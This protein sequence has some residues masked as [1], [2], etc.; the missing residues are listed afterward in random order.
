VIPRAALV[1]WGAK[2]P[3][4]TDEDIE[5]DLIMSRLMI[6][7]AND[8]LLGPELVMRGGTCLHKIHLPEPLRYSEDLDYNRRT[9]SG[10]GPYVNAIEAVAKN[11]GLRMKKF[12]RGGQM[13]TVVLDCDS[14]GGLRLIRIKVETNVR[15]TTPCYPII[16]RPHEVKSSWWSGRADVPTFELAELMGTKLR[17]LYQRSRGRDLFDLW[18]VLTETKVDDDRLVAAFHH[19]MGTEAFGFPQLREN[20]RDKL[21]DTAFSND[22]SDL[23][24]ATPTGYDL[25]KAADLFMERIGSRL[26]NAPPIEEI[27]NGGWRA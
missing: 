7:I 11:I 22:L 4:P 2:V 19:Y 17:A 14:T 10:I 15:E 9:N 8:A 1:Q 24:R 6:D 5:Q 27:N 3:W 20:L 26:K 16:T 23:V 25:T 18:H 13:A 12:K 21:A